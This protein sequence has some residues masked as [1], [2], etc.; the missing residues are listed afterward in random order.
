MG[1]QNNIAELVSLSLSVVRMSF[2]GPFY[3][4]TLSTTYF[5]VN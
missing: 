2:K 4:T 5:H 3:H 1:R